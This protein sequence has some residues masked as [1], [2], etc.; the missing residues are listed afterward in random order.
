M[1]AIAGCAI[2][3]TNEFMMITIRSVI[4]LC[5]LFFNQGNLHMKLHIHSFSDVESEVAG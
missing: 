1:V 5:F 2:L 4:L 3:I